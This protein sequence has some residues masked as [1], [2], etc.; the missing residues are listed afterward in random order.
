MGI[1]CCGV[2]DGLHHLVLGAWQHAV[3]TLEN[4]PH[5][6]FGNTPRVSCATKAEPDLDPLRQD[7]GWS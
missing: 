7:R 1:S 2:R 4:D 3:F 5:F 6:Q